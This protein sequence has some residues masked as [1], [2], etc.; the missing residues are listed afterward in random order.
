LDSLNLAVE[1]T[2]V[3]MVIHLEKQVGL[4]YGVHTICSTGDSI[5][6]LVA[7]DEIGFQI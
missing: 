4:L 5:R 6:S 3:G 7:N 2:V 1:D